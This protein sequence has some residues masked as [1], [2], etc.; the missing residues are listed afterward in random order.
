M[1]YK[2]GFCGRNTKSE[3]AN[4]IVTCIRPVRYEKFIKTRGSRREDDTGSRFVCANEGWEIAKEAKI[5]DNCNQ[6][7]VDFQ[8]EVIDEVKVVN[9]FG[10]YIK[11]D[12]SSRPRNDD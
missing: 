8:A 9:Y 4:S 10:S 11:K 7:N 2:C 1:G 5:C 3:R 12:E 6:K